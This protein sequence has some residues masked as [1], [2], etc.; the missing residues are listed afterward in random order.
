M[1]IKKE[2]KKD[3]P[4]KEE[5]K[6]DD[7]EKPKT[8][9]QKLENI[10]AAQRK[11]WVYVPDNYTPDVAHGLVIW[12]HPAGRDGRDADDMVSLWAGFCETHK[13][14]MIGPTA[15]APSGWVAGEA[16]A[17]MD[18]VR[19]VRTRYTIDPKRVIAHGQ[20]VG[21]QMAYYLGINKREVVRG[22]APVGAVLASN[23]KDPVAAQRVEFLV[24]AG[25]KDPLA[26]EIAESPKKLADKK[27]KALYREMKVTGKEYVNDDPD[28]FAQLVRWIDSMDKQ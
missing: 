25:A 27:Y 14:I 22:A 17:V 21:G 26:K 12:L 1:P 23:P 18:D 7:K 28:V 20:G 3:E 5:A 6:K 8:G 4:K 24:I 9:L 13:L 19:W 2:V 10:G 11:F 15:Q 16:E